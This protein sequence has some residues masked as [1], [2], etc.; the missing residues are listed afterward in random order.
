MMV[1]R[2]TPDDAS[3]LARLLAAS[4][5][6][7]YRG[8]VPDEFMDGVDDTRWFQ[9][10]KDSLS[11]GSEEIHIAEIASATVGL[12]TFGPCQDP[13]VNQELTGE[14]RRIYVLPGYW[15]R[16]IGRV[17]CRYAEEALRQGGCRACVLWVLAGNVRGLRFYEA[18]G[19]TTDGATKAIE[20]GASLQSV[21][22]CRELP[23]ERGECQ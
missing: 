16:G 4:W 17:L 20:L 22:L 7:A 10:L 15:R 13:D 1:R 23:D 18:L 14:I 9:R 6:A 11:E 12:V 19:Y 3:T 21:R 2:A 8:I 5:Q